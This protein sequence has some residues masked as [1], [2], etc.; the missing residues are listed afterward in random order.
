MPDLTPEDSAARLHGTLVEILK[1]LNRAEIEEPEGEGLEAPEILVRLR[2]GPVPMLVDA[3]FDRA[4]TTLVANE[5]AG[6]VEAPQYAW[7]RERTLGKRY[8]LS[9]SGKQYL[10]D[11]LQKSSRIE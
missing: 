9:P 5:L 4:L 10:L 1:Q 7:D 2:K 3:D 6:V 11:Q 8:T